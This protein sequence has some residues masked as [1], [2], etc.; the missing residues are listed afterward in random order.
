MHLYTSVFLQATITPARYRAYGFSPGKKF[1][2]NDASVS[3]ALQSTMLWYVLQV[4]V[5]L[6]GV[7]GNGLR[8]W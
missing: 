4:V 3:T 8:V 1:D 7:E 6:R 5:H 2:S